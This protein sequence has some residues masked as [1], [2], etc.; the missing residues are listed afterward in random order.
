MKPGL[1]VSSEVGA[2]RK[3]LLHRPG[4][5]VETLTP[6]MLENLLF[7][8]IPWLKKL[9]EE[10]DGFADLLRKQGCEVYYYSDLLR[11]VLH[12]TNLAREVAEY[13]VP[14]GR[15]PQSSLRNEVLEFL[16][17][18]SADA[19]VEVMIAGLRKDE[20]SHGRRNRS[21]SWWIQED[22]PF[23]IDPLPNLYFTRD[24]GMIIGTG[25]VLGLMQTQARS[26][27]VYLL[28]LI[29]CHH[30]L[31][32]P[33]RD[34]LWYGPNNDKDWQNYAT[35]WHGP[36]NSLEGGDIL[37]LS[38]TAVVM[39]VSMR[40]SVNAVETLAEHLFRS[41][42][43][44]REILVVKIPV[45]RAC[46]HLDT[47]LTMVDWDS[48]ILFPGIADSIQVFKLSPGRAGTLKI[49]EARSLEKGL[50][51]VLG[52]HRVR[53][54]A[55]GIRDGNIA[56]RE[57]WNNSANTLAI[58][59]GKIIT[60]NRNNSANEL[61]EKA[62]IEVLEIDGSELTRGRGGPRCM[63]MPILRDNSP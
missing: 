37:V 42:S 63:S 8:D 32:A 11:E 31:F 15:L 52:V 24:P 6:E 16:L 25:M 21:L 39:G 53:L 48:F 43:G 19:L 46:M 29:R 28:N 57:Q 45:A 38:D 18:M 58:A 4:K 26:R 36:G 12:D 3:V 2:L 10:H 59:P 40:S 60:Y 17:A 62:G 56:A 41:D 55:S 33:V 54:I 44:I 51:D 61:F 5:E 9:R 27:E 49:K 30:E 7:E 34:R 13:L 20:I 22:F 23:Y 47:V 35:Q 50:A 1:V 14:T